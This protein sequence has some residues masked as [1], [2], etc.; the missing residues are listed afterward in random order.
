MEIV[1]L[2][3]RDVPPTETIRRLVHEQAAR[4]DR[5]C[6]SVTSCR[7]AIEHPQRHQRSGN[8]YRVRIE[9]TVPPHKDLVI[10]Q[11]PQDNEMHTGLPAIVRKAF[12]AVQRQL[13][14]VAR[15]RRGAAG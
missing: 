2:S 14:E 7:V 12:R 1:E 15:L 11:D 10:V 9:V 6:A 3:F 13:K 4:L 5:F 8:A